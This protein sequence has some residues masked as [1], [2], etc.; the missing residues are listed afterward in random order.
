MDGSSFAT[1]AG[2]PV[3]YRSHKCGS[4]SPSE[5]AKSGD[6]ESAARAKTTPAWRRHGHLAESK[7]FEPDDPRRVARM[8]VTSGGSRP[9]APVAT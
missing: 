3:P 4:L 8:S 6:A 2:W 9:S 7:G 5:A 1:E